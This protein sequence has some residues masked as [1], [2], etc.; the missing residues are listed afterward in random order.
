MSHCKPCLP[1]KTVLFRETN[2]HRAHSGWFI[3]GKKDWVFQSEVPVYRKKKNILKK[4]SQML[5]SMSTS[6]RNDLNLAV[7][8]KDFYFPNFKLKIYVA[9]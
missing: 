2:V 1:L 9:V 6:I 8:L 5:L 4:K 7:P 3:T